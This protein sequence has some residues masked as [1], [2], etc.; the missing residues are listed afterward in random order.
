[1]DTIEERVAYYR[2]LDN[3]KLIA[4]AKSVRSNEL[5]LVMRE[6]AA[7]NDTWAGLV[8]T[9]AELGTLKGKGAN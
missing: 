1:M 3:E 9:R 4:L 2:S 8:P 6:R 7:D 5:M